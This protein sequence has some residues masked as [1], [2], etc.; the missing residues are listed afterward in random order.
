MQYQLFS[1]TKKLLLTFLLAPIIL[2]AVYYD[3]WGILNDDDFELEKQG[4][5]T[6]ALGS[7]I[8]EEP[9]WESFNKWQCFSTNSAEAYC[10][11]IGHGQLSAVSISAVDDS[12]KRYELSDEPVSN[13]TC[14]QQLLDWQQLLE[15]EHGFCVYA[16]YLQ[17]ID[18]NHELWIVS[19]LKTQKGVWDFDST[20]WRNY[21]E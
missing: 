17:N 15:G 4:S 13:E 5:K 20:V 8:G 18:D 3:G 9:Y 16:A 19:R 11:I 21:V 6:R 1:N 10:A 14:A 12:G 2:A 7:A